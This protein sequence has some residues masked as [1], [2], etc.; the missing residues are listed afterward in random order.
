[1]P[2]QIHWRPI[3]TLD[4]ATIDNSLITLKVDGRPVIASW[5]TDTVTEQTFWWNGDVTDEGEKIEI[6]N[7]TDWALVDLNAYRCYYEALIDRSKA[8]ASQ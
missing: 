4:N 1:M 6:T 7:P 2:P 5:H 3:N 8:S